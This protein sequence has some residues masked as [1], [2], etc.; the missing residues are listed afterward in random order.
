MK[1][2]TRFIEVI[3]SFF[4]ILVAGLIYFGFRPEKL[5]MF[6]WAEWLGLRDVIQTYRSVCSTVVL[7]EWIKYSLPDGLWTISYLLL[8]DSIWMDSRN[9]MFM[10][11][12][13]IMPLIAIVLEFFQLFGLLTGTFDIVD[14]CCYLGAITIFLFYKYQILQVSKI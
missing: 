5:A 11:F 13:L 7:P 8:L 4:C 9:R 2:K 10:L 3:F 6:T 1:N 14:L 12:A